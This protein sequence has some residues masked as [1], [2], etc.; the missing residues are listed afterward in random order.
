MMQNKGSLQITGHLNNNIKSDRAHSDD[1]DATATNV[2]ER[3]AARDNTNANEIFPATTTH[4]PS[5]APLSAQLGAQNETSRGRK[6]SESVAIKLEYNKNAST[7]EKP[8]LVPTA[9]V[10]D[11][12]GH[13][14]DGG[15]DKKNKKPLDRVNN[16]K[17]IKLT[18]SSNSRKLMPFIGETG[19]QRRRISGGPKSVFAQQSI[20][21]HTPTPPPLLLLSSLSTSIGDVA[22]AM[23]TPDN[24]DSREATIQPLTSPT[25][26]PT[27]ST[28]ASHVTSSP[29]DITSTTNTSPQAPFQ[30][31]PALITLS[32]AAVTKTVDEQKTLPI[33]SKQIIFQRLPQITPTRDEV[34]NSLNPSSS[35]KVFATTTTSSVATTTAP[36]AGKVVNETEDGTRKENLPKTGASSS[37]KTTSKERTPSPVIWRNDDDNA[38]A[39]VPDSTG[40]QV[41]NGKLMR[42]KVVVVAQ[43]PTTSSSVSLAQQPTTTKGLIEDTASTEDDNDNPL[44]KLWQQ[45]STHLSSHTTIP[46]PEANPD[47]LSVSQSNTSGA[48]GSGDDVN[49]RKNLIRTKSDG[50]KKPTI[51]RST[52]ASLKSETI[53]IND[54]NND[55]QDDNS[56]AA[57]AEAAWQVRRRVG[58]E[59]TETEEDATEEDVLKLSSRHPHHGALAKESGEIYVAENSLSVAELVV[60]A[61]SKS[62]PQTSSG[63]ITANRGRPDKLSQ[64]NTNAI[65][66]AEGEALTAGAGVLSRAPWNE[67]IKDDGGRSKDTTENGDGDGTDDGIEAGNSDNYHH[68]QPHP[69]LFIVI[70]ASIGIVLSIGLFRCKQSWTHRHYPLPDTGDINQTY[71]H[72]QPQQPPLRR[73]FDYHQQRMATRPS[74]S[75]SSA[76][77]NDSYE[78]GR[79]DAFL[80]SSPADEFGAQRQQQQRFAGSEDDYYRCTNWRDRV[81]VSD[82]DNHQLCD[83]AD[84]VDVQLT[85]RAERKSVKFDL[86]PMKILSPNDHQPFLQPMI[87]TSD[88]DYDGTAI[89]DN[90]SSRR[91]GSD[92]GVDR[93]HKSSSSSSSPLELW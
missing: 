69:G 18:D 66:V 1:D 63:D 22:G 60:L 15:V 6:S 45:A 7:D 11:S 77:D 25:S 32:P 90:N 42:K 79:G 81:P 3:A 87:M 36:S 58:M 70:G 39:T 50:N 34:H 93:G 26:T 9:D 38:T 75:S 40:K 12:T 80:S 51:T 76:V 5:L 59:Q 4:S 48:G 17:L 29:A 68:R 13:D 73:Q 56:A 47:G 33:S 41:A 88:C 61:P 16:K 86:L 46:P 30:S 78:G 64:L 85:P 83:G 14:D 53:L 72:S 82:K 43:Q 71:T 52:P 28:R 49:E 55:A 20:L 27:T 62:S 89:E 44:L 54:R 57:G 31:M 8:V 84:F 65:H 91:R 92:M 2:N 23:T 10:R 21:S 37:A 19:Q 67:H 24:G 35:G 74:S